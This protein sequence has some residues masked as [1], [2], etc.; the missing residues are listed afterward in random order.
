MFQLLLDQYPQLKKP[1]R[2]SE[3]KGEGLARK[4][5]SYFKH[6]GSKRE[7]VFLLSISLSA[8]FYHLSLPPHFIHLFI[9]LFSQLV[10]IEGTEN[11]LG[12]Q[13]TPLSSRHW[14]PSVVRASGNKYSVVRQ[15][16]PKRKIKWLKRN[17][18]EG[19]KE[20]RYFK[21]DWKTSLMRWPWTG[22]R[23]P[24]WGSAKDKS[25]EMEF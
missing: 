17:K 22:T 6:G 24:G 4:N 14:L 9:L 21:D 1:R 10:F 18:W 2:K 25:P 5:H 13:K 8:R 3:G 12:H 7:Q 20:L 16:M 23:V 19:E 11:W 15:L